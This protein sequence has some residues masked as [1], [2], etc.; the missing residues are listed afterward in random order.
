MGVKILYD[1]YIDP[2]SV[3]ATAYSSQNAS[4]PASNL[5]TFPRRSKV[6]R[7]S[8][9]SSAQYLSWDLGATSQPKAFI[10]IGRK[11]VPINIST[12][13][14]TIK[15]LGNDT[16]VWTSPSYEKAISYD[17]R[18]LQII[19]STALASH[20][21][22]RLSIDDTS[23]TDGYIE[24]GWCFLGDYFEPSSGSAV[25]PL[26]AGYIDYSTTSYSLAGQSYSEIRGYTEQFGLRWQYLDK[27][28]K[29]AIDVIFDEYGT[30]TPFFI[31]LD[32]DSVIGSTANYYTRYVKFAQPIAWSYDMA[33]YFSC[34]MVL[35]EEL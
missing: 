17:T 4:F 9:V 10:A 23:N 28:D 12:S 27:T 29:E 14:A 3:N 30:H 11:D 5:F 35:R 21:Y 19:S 13:G 6:W 18:A 1:N 25:F 16:D 15:L 2:A 7:S 22:W 32:P 26:S 34:D 20:R 33:G 24:L 8:T 31:V